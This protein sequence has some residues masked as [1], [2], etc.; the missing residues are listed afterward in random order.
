VKILIATAALLM[1]VSTLASAQDAD[2]PY[3]G[4]GY[5]FFGVGP[6]VGSGYNPVIKQV[7]F[8]GE[9]FLYKGLGAGAEAAYAI[10]VT[11]R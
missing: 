9:G 5:L 4:Q 7:G 6:G 3:R 2:H 8:G 10:G 1:M 11:F